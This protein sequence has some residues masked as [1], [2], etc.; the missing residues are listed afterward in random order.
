MRHYVIFHTPP[1]GQFCPLAAFSI[2]QS[3]YKAGCFFP[4]S[5]A[6]FALSLSTL[7]GVNPE[8]PAPLFCGIDTVPARWYLS[9]GSTVHFYHCDLSDTYTLLWPDAANPDCIFLKN[10]PFASPP[11]VFNLSGEE[12]EKASFYTFPHLDP[13]LPSPRCLLAHPS[14][15]PLCGVHSLFPVQ[16]GPHMILLLPNVPGLHMALQTGF[17]ISGTEEAAYA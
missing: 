1:E 8:L 10:V 6:T 16:I 9:L 17:P 14:H 11:N 2:Y 3:A 5:P 13:L 12:D 4:H 7:P 15:S